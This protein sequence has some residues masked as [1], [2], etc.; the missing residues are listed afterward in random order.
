MFVGGFNIL[1][2]RQTTS[3]LLLLV[4]SCHA[5]NSLKISIKYYPKFCLFLHQ[6]TFPPIEPVI[7]AFVS[8]FSH[9]SSRGSAWQGQFPAQKLRL[10]WSSTCKLGMFCGCTARRCWTSARCHPHTAT[11]PGTD[12]QTKPHMT[13]WSNRGEY[14]FCNITIQQIH[15]LTHHIQEEELFAGI[16]KPCYIY[17]TRTNLC[18]AFAW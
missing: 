18:L 3:V 6:H 13:W 7:Q 1:A 2:H 5:T 10:A 15:N 9:N 4:M 17:L 14:N 8:P 16:T 11:D 12:L